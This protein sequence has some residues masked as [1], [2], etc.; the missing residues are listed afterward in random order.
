MFVDDRFAIRRGQ[1]VDGRGARR[2]RGKDWRAGRGKVQHM[3]NRDTRAIRL[4][5]QL[6]SGIAGGGFVGQR[7]R[8]MTI[9]VLVVD[10]HDDG[11][12]SKQRG[13][14][15]QAGRQ[16]NDLAQGTGGHAAP[17]VG[18]SAFLAAWVFPS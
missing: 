18:R 12:G 16:A 11:F 3:D 13:A 4:G 15:V 8:T 10:Q 17:P 5:A 2:V 7:Q 6:A 9:F 14:G 1:A